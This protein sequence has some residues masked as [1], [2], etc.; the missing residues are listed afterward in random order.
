MSGFGI[1]NLQGVTLTP[2]FVFGINGGLKNNIHLIEDDKK[3]LYVA[4][5]NVV[6][7]APDERSQVFIP[8]T[9]GVQNISAVAVSNKAHLL[10]VCERTYKIALCSLYNLQTRKKVRVIPEVEHEAD[11][12]AKE[13]LDVAFCPKD[14]NR[15]LVTLAG[16]PDWCVH[17]WQHD[18][19]KCHT[20]INLNLP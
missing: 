4:G 3:L 18:M 15:Y 1:G 17:L 16:R 20:R 13:F 12:K 6:V 19:F 11:Y 10:A 7:Y 5:H 14:P 9:E 2:K 8:G